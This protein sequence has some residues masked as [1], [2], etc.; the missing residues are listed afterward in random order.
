MKVDTEIFFF[1]FKFQVMADAIVT[2]QWFAYKPQV[3]DRDWHLFPPSLREINADIH[4][5]LLSSDPKD[6]VIH[7]RVLAILNN[8]SHIHK[9]LQAITRTPKFSGLLV[10]SSY[11]AWFP[12]KYSPIYVLMYANIQKQI[13]LDTASESEYIM[14]SFWFYCHLTW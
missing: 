2:R 9:S 12:L 3:H 11:K 5:Q 7:A 8:Q 10:L 4:Q 14:S 13:K 1:F 6:D